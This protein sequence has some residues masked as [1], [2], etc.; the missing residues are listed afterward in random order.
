MITANTM[1]VTFL[2]STACLLVMP[3]V[4]TATPIIDDRKINMPLTAMWLAV[5]AMLG[6]GTIPAIFFIMKEDYRMELFRRCGMKSLRITTWIGSGTESR[7]RAEG[8]RSHSKTV[9]TTATRGS[10]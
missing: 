8:S 10:T 6:Y 5:F 7:S 9:S 4:A 1:F 3:I 2:W